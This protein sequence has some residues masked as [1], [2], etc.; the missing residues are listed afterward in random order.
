MMTESD[1]VADGGQAV[2]LKI[3]LSLFLALGLAGHNAPLLGQDA[4][5]LSNQSLTAL[6]AYEERLE[7]LES[8]Y[9][10]YH[11]SLLEPLQ[12]MEGLLQAMGNFERVAQLQRRRL[13]ISRT[14]FGFE[15]LALISLL[16]EMITTELQLHD[17]QQV[18][19]YLEH[20]RY[21]YAVNSG[22]DSEDV[23]LAMARQAQWLLTEVYLDPERDPEDLVL[24]AR[25]IY[26]S[27]LDL[28]EDKYG[29]HS[30]ELIPWLYN[31]ALSLYY[32]VAMMNTDSGVAGDTIQEVSLRD[33]LSRLH[34][35]RASSG[36]R[37]LNLYGP[38]SRVPIVD[39]DEPVGVA[40]LRQ[41]KGFVNDIE[42]I[43]IENDDTELLG[44]AAIYQGDFNVLMHRSSG[45]R[46]YREARELLLQAGLPAERIDRFFAL[47]MVLPM[48]EFFT[49][50]AALEG[51]QQS[52]V[53]ELGEAADNDTGGTHLGVLTAWDED[54]RAIAIPR[55]PQGIAELQIGMNVVDL[56]FRISS[57]GQVSSVDVLS[58]EPDEK[59]IERTAWR[60]LREISFRPAF[61]D[62]RTRAIR[63]ARIR[64]RFHMRE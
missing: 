57:R 5:T 27:A 44:L 12:S 9:G 11:A 3:L 33:G 2:V 34:S 28:A 63:D 47:P 32:L 46:D 24:D 6:A 51:Y 39:A 55:P 62:N 10:P 19:D 31:R 18:S 43:G 61:I 38:S 30:P 50:F 41:A 53:K 25:E 36:L 15:N 29:E 14:E 26:D 21:L 60:A 16:E 49:D 37:S 8:E 52:L 1:R 40:Y 23:L 20:I 17:W 35:A 56:E 4:V 48:P 42:S 45:L 58:V 54:L 59:R 64:Y 7:E 22:A 13:Q